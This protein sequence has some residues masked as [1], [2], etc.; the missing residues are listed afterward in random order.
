[1]V[2]A[3]REDVLAITLDWVRNSESDCN[4]YNLA[5]KNINVRASGQKGGKERRTRKTQK[6]ATPAY[7]ITNKEQLAFAPLGSWVLPRGPEGTTQTL[8][9]VTRPSAPIPLSSQTRTSSN[10][11]LTVEPEAAS[12]GL[13]LGQAM[14]QRATSATMRSQYLSTAN[15]SVTVSNEEQQE[16][17]ALDGWHPTGL[18]QAM[19]QPIPTLLPSQNAVV[20]ST[21]H[22]MYLPTYPTMQ[23]HQPSVFFQSLNRYVP[24][25]NDNPFVIM[26]INGRIKKCAGCR[27]EFSDPFGPVFVGLVVRHSER[28]YYNDKNGFRR[29]GNEQARYYHPEKAC[30]MAR[31]QDFRSSMLQLHPEVVIDDFQASHLHQQL[32]IEVS[33]AV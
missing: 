12:I 8:P 17:A 24:W 3:E 33:P 6:K 31:H 5:T 14:E 4:L 9:Q 13:G 23:S 25:H 27:R 18:A 10:P 32:S 1:M 28:D 16:Y 11:M 7:T 29:I 20:P 26:N 19:V 15:L 30:L 22:S 2:V 21:C